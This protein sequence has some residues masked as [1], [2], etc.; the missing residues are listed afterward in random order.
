MAV[1]L[2]W[3][4]QIIRHCLELKLE[5][6]FQRNRLWVKKLTDMLIVLSH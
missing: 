1:A 5:K 2:K 3:L 4:Y 6:Y